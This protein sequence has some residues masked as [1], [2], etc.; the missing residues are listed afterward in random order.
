MILRRYIA[1]QIWSSVALVLFAL[2]SLF[3]FL[4]LLQE[5]D[6][7]GRAGYRFQHALIYVALQ[8]PSTLRL[9]L[10]LAAL[11]GTITALAQLAAG[12]QFTI[13]RAAGL[14]PLGAVRAVLGAAVLLVG[15]TFVV[16]EY[17][18]P[19][20]EVAAEKLRLSLLGRAASTDLRSGFWIKDVVFD[21]SGSQTG[22]RFVNA[23]EVL[24]DGSLRDIRL[25][26]FDAGMRLRSFAVAGTAVFERDETNPG[27]RLRDVTETRL[28]MLPGANRFDPP[29][30]ALATAV[31]HEPERLW[32]TTLD[33]SIVSSAFLKPD[34]MSLTALWNYVEHLKLTRQKSLKYEVALWRKL[35]DPFT[36]AVMMLLALPFAYL[37]TRSGG[38]SLKV[39]A[40][41][42]L[43]VGFHFLNNL[44]AHLG[45]LN[46]WPA[47]MPA[48]LPSLLSL[49]LAAGWL[50]WVSRH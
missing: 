24:A 32:P 3:F 47:W 22:V 15:L 37:H 44:S 31:V 38:V 49:L 2:I 35:V 28:S 29:E 23:R 45:L 8:M 50:R 11:I 20:A 1:R 46:G 25:Y 14:S 10:P 4:D 13:M 30:L 34:N 43:G 16:G 42:L 41:I 26:E 36:V 21:G 33:A 39:F 5:M 12:S 27:W 40:G 6:D 19:T 18:A 9:L 17:V 48:A 7:V